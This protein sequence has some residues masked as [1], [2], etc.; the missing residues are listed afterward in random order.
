M[1]RKPGSVPGHPK[2]R[3]PLL[4]PRLW[5]LPVGCCRRPHRMAWDA[6][7]QRSPALPKPRLQL[8]SQ[9][10]QPERTMELQRKKPVEA[11]SEDPPTPFSKGQTL[12]QGR[13]GTSDHDSPP[14]RWR[15]HLAC[16]PSSRAWSCGSRR[17]LPR[18]GRILRPGLPSS[19]EPC[20]FSSRGAALGPQL[21]L[22]FL[23]GR[24]GGPSLSLS[25]LAHPSPP[26]LP[27]A[28]THPPPS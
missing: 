26:R 24:V 20:S 14:L 6:G 1:G 23:G 10:G 12:S 25:P 4:A 19:Y 15:K 18:A 22:G 5:G 7:A 21:F 11:T 8:P 9:S 13:T 27:I 16:G 2:N 17:T 28:T 3:A